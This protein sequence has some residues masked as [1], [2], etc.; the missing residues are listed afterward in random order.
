MAKSE[1]R[2]EHLPL[3]YGVAQDVAGGPESDE[4][5]SHLQQDSLGNVAMHVVAEF[6]RQHG[7]DFIVGVI[8]QERVG[9]D[10]AARFA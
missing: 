7:F 9:N 6:V 1:T 2:L 5:N 10:D 4:G 3:L 8:V